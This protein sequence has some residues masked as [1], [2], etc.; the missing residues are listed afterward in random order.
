VNSAT[1]LMKI[2]KRCLKPVQIK[3]AM[4]IGRCVLL[5]TNDTKGIQTIK[6]QVMAGEVM[7]DVE[8]FQNYGMTSHVPS[9]S[10]GVILFPLGNREHG[11]CVALDNRNVRL[12]QLEQGEVALYTDEGDTII[13][14]R[15]NK[16]EINGGEEVSVNT[17][18]AKVNATLKAEVTTADA[19][20][21]A[22]T[23]AD[24]TAPI[25][26]LT[27]IVNVI[28]ALN[29]GGTGGAPTTIDMKGQINLEGS[30]DAT[31]EISDANGSMQE[32]RDT[33]N[34]HTH[35]ENNNLNGPTQGPNTQMT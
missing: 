15:G 10:E 23:K 12:K 32:M 26:N 11:I 1:E 13:L 20:V 7:E 34:S 27:G 4:L 29:V 22:S 21:T 17:K 6:A 33:F 18:T 28:G 2:I 9:N 5:A 24:I 3:I 8:R 16:I 19:V 35:N 31:A 30:M 25:I 14:K